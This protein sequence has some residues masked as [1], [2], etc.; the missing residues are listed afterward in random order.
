MMGYYKSV[1]GS[2]EKQTKKK[3][4]N[5]MS[6]TKTKS[7]TVPWS[8]GGIFMFTFTPAVYRPFSL[9]NAF[10]DMTENET[11]LRYPTDVIDADDAYKL[12]IDLPGYQKDEISLSLETKY[13]TIEAK[14]KESEEGEVEPKYLRR[15]RTKGSFSR[16]YTVQNIEKNGITASYEN[17]VLTVTLPKIKPIEPEKLTFSVQ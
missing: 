10:F 11:R 14:H 8:T 16:T 15:E 9:A 5:P 7:Y 1:V 3:T 6:F 12:V 17:G 13:F 2:E 4:A